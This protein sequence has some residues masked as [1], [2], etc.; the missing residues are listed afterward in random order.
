MKSLIGRPSPLRY[1]F[2]L[3]V[4]ALGVASI[5]AT[6]PSSVTQ[7]SNTWY[8]ANWNCNNVS[9]CIADMGHNTGSAGPFCSTTPCDAWKQAY[10]ISATCG[11]TAAYPIYNAPAAGTCSNYS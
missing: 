9:G 6:N 5:L 4:V 11:P 10:I 3:P 2:L 7:P 1:L 8:Y